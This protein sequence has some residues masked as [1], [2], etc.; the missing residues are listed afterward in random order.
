MDF[1]NSAPVEHLP[2]FFKPLFW[3]YSFDSLDLEKHKKNIILNVINYGDWEHWRWI[4]NYYGKDN[5][6]Q[7]LVET[8]A[9]ELRPQVRKLVA[10]VFG[11]S[12]FKYTSRGVKIRA[13][14]S[15]VETS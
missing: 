12:E 11:V 13:I 1:Q 6:R 5:I 2:D 15:L 14:K 3:S 4:S 10:I 7:V 8:P 9:S